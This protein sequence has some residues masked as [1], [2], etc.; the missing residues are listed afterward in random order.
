MS[1]PFEQILAAEIAVVQRFITLLGEE[2]AALSSGTL[3]GLERIVAEKTRL[4]GELDGVGKARETYF[5]EI[6][7][8]NDGNAIADW[9]DK[10]P[11][12]R[13]T[14][15]WQKLQALA[16]EAKAL[17]ELNGQCIALLAR[18]NKQI[19]DTLTGKTGRNN[20]YGPDGQPSSGSGF[21]I[22][23]AV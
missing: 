9:L 12:V 5:A 17:N 4:S 16:R 10:A 21:R 20:L 15:G 3:E 6:G 2:K 22:V 13:I 11:D 8:G 7:I 14:Q 1:A 23:D 18:N 19:L